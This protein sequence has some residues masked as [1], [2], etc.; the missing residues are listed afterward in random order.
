MCSSDLNDE[1]ALAVTV[2]Q[3]ASND[4]RAVYKNTS[5]D[6]RR[7]KH[8]QMF[9][10]ANSLPG[11]T[12]VE[13]G[14][15]SLFLRLGTD[16]KNNFYEYEIPLK[17]TPDGLYPNSDAGARI[18]WPEENMLDIDLSVFT[19]AKRNRNRQKS[20]GLI[21]YAQLYSEYDANRPANKISVMGNPTLGEVRII[22]IGVR[23]NSRDARSVEV[24][25]NELRLQEF[26]NN[27]GW[28]AREIGRAHV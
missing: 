14:Q 20:L 2:K 6:F 18:V 4:A 28:A 8:L 1:Q 22:M 7:Y 3:L 11:E 21:S 23:N 24:W 9:A 17:I 5:F 19:A 26:S 25:A 13:D 10:H 15:V 12:P 27:G 16:Y